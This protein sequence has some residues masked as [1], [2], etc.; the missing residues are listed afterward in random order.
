MFERP[1]CARLHAESFEPT[2]VFPQTMVDKRRST[3]RPSRLPALFILPTF[4]K[5]QVVWRRLC[6]VVRFPS[7]LVEHGLTDAP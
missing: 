2:I 6:D 1:V 3:L 5:V 4:A 7:C